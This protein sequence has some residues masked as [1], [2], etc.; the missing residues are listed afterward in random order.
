ENKGHIFSGYQM[1]CEDW[2]TL[3]LQKLPPPQ[4]P[5]LAK[6][7]RNLVTEP[8]QAVLGRTIEVLQEIDLR[9]F[10]IHFLDSWTLTLSIQ[11]ESPKTLINYIQEMEQ[12]G[13]LAR[14]QIHPDFKEI[15]T[16]GKL[17]NLNTSAWKENYHNLTEPDE[18]H[19]G[20]GSHYMYLLLLPHPNKASPSLSTSIMTRVLLSPHEINRNLYDILDNILKSDPCST[21]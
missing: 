20:N 19:I 4:T 13:L 16:C 21:D 8:Q 15:Q 9:T 6:K 12:T 17:T 11:N 1:D 5:P 18:V 2:N 3:L 10:P 14:I 7:G